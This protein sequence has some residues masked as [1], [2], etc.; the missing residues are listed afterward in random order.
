MKVIIISGQDHYLSGE[1]RNSLIFLYPNSSVI[2]VQLDFNRRKD[3]MLKVVSNYVIALCKLSTADFVIVF[4]PIIIYLP[5]LLNFKKKIVLYFDFFPIH[6]KEIG[7][8][9][10]MFYLMRKIE[11]L[12]FKKF[13]SFRGMMTQKNIQFASKYFHIDSF[14]LNEVPLWSTRASID[15]FPI[16]NRA[17]KKLFFGGQLNKGRNLDFFIDFINYSSISQTSYEFHIFGSGIYSDKFIELSERLTTVFFYGDVPYDNFI[18]LIS[19]MDIGLVFTNTDVT[20][21]TYP[22]KSLDI[23]RIGKP[24]TGVVERSTDFF[25][26][27]NSSNAGRVVT[28]NSVTDLEACISEIYSD[29][30]FFSNSAQ[31]LFKIR[32]YYTASLLPLKKFIDEYKK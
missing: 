22:S 23:L 3:N 30:S 28:S 2:L 32:H 13:V 4:S 8:K 17:S 1:L 11:K 19:N 5:F 20:V 26:I 29:Y 18:D 24:I 21:P 6:Q 7:V 9:I 31:N 16:L 25:E 15:N 27:I 10:P 12:L 14:K